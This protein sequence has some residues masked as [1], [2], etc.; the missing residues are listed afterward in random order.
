MP[1]GMKLMVY[2]YSGVLENVVQLTGYDYL[3]ILLYEESELVKAVFDNVGRCLVKY[4]EIIASYE[5]VGL[6]MSND[7][8]GF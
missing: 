3:C 5:S 4:Y 6:I 7:D 1:D 8:W 2:G